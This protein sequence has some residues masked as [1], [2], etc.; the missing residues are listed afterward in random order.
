M[1]DSVG[2]DDEHDEI[3]PAHAREHVLDEPLV[4]GHV[5][6]RHGETLDHGVRETEIDRDAA[7]FFFLQPIGI[8]PGERLHQRALP[9]IDVPGGS[10]DEGFHVKKRSPRRTQRTQRTQRETTTETQRHR[11]GRSPLRGAT[12]SASPLRVSV[13]QW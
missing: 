13:P 6:E 5:H 12:S 4:P 8:G 11:D 2:R 9:V 3:D 1:T 10:D 7:R